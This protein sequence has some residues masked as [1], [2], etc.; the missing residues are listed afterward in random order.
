MMD[1]ATKYEDV[2]AERL[3]EHDQVKIYPIP[4]NDRI[5]IE[6]PEA[7]SNRSIYIFDTFGKAVTIEKVDAN[8]QRLRVPVTHLPDGVYLIQIKRGGHSSFH[9]FVISK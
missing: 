9:R 6:L 3:G 7:T 1:F 8:K 2:I 4:T 5:T